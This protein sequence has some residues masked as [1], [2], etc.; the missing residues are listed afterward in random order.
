MLDKNYLMTCSIAYGQF[1]FK[2]LNAYSGV[3]K[4]PVYGEAY[5]N[6]F[7]D[8]ESQNP[9]LEPG[10]LRIVK[11][12]LPLEVFKYFSEENNKYVERIGVIEESPIHFY[13][14]WMLNTNLF[15]DIKK[16]YKIAKEYPYS[17]YRLILKKYAK[18]LD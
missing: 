9:K 5:L 15:S 4:L 13:V 7:L 8:N 6:A 2:D 17:A 14:H 16:E 12:G 1:Y 3:E 18:N 11:K 10:F